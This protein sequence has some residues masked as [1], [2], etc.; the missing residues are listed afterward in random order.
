MEAPTA[1][2][3]VKVSTGGPPADGIVFDIP[4]ARKVVVVVIDPPRGPMRR[5]T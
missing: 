5:C 1:G 2:A 4:S 3:L